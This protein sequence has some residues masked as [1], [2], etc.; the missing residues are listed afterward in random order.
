MQILLDRAGF[1]PGEI[2]GRA[3][4]NTR[5]ALATFL[6][7]RG[8]ADDDTATVREAL[9]DA[10]DTI[11]SYDITA[12]DAAGPFVE[13]IPEDMIERARLP[14]LHYTSVIEALS[15]KFHAAPALLKRLNPQARFAAG[16]RIRVPNV[17]PLSGANERVASAWENGGENAAK[18][19][20][21]D[22]KVVV[23]KAA[24]ALDVYDAS[25][26]IIFHAPVTSGSE[27]DPLP[28]G[29]WT[30]TAIV[31]N[32]TFNYNPALFWDA[33]PKSAKARI[34]AGPNN[35]VGV[36]WIDIDKPHYGLHGTPEPAAVGHST[37]HG[38]VRLT[39]WDA[40]KV[41]NL[42]ARG[43]PVVFEE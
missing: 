1:S 31:R 38:C 19:P 4:R 42:V 22:V 26:Q 17:V 18:T 6:A 41:A 23:S 27:H 8:L 14:G 15:E 10:G 24:S 34:P 28:I 29:T 25:G 9:G 13:T 7:A 36:V 32:P 2:D 21:G 35:P 39:N 3:G 5:A 43:T 40:E 16:E 30:V 11:V 37:S 20:A 12:D 33:D